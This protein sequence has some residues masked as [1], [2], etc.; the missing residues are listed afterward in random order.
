MWLPPKE[1]LYNRKDKHPYDESGGGGKDNVI[2]QWLAR[3]LIWQAQ[4]EDGAIPLKSNWGRVQAPANMKVMRM[5]REGNLPAVTVF[6]V[7]G[8]SSSVQQCQY[9]NSI[10]GGIGQPLG[11]QDT[12][13]HMI[14]VEGC[15]WN[16]IKST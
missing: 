11:V 3:L 14:N 2:L 7:E 8:I 13:D 10:R 1:L 16:R 9:G 6:Q 12:G 4:E 15:P 5:P